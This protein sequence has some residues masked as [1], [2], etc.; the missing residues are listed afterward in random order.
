MSVTGMA[1]FPQNNQELG[2]VSCSRF[3]QLRYLFGVT[4]G[5]QGLESPQHVIFTEK[6]RFKLGKGVIHGHRVKT[7]ASF[8]AFMF[9]ILLFPD[10]F[11]KVRDGLLG[12]DGG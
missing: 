3:H 1:D 5:C 10:K 9:N 11:Q 2:P 4:E 6:V 7:T 8:G 12:I